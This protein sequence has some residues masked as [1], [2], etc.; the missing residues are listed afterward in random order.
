MCIMHYSVG[1]DS[2][3]TYASVVKDGLSYYLNQ[4][5]LLARHLI[6]YKPQCTIIIVE[7]I[8]VCG[9]FRIIFDNN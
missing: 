2:D 8:H 9:G 5:A 3:L 6:V 1:V 7:N 4:E